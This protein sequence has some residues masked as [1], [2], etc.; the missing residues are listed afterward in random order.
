MVNIEMQV[1]KINKNITRYT[2]SGAYRESIK[3]AMGHFNTSVMSRMFDNYNAAILTANPEVSLNVLGANIGDELQIFI[4]HV[5]QVKAS[6]FPKYDNAVILEGTRSKIFLLDVWSLH[7]LFE[8]GFS[9]FDM[10]LS[11]GVKVPE[12][13]EYRLTAKSGVI[14]DVER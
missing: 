9:R 11:V 13:Y 10:I 12:W 3:F 6:K 8:R 14:I 4:P 1:S 2:V 7:S 5:E